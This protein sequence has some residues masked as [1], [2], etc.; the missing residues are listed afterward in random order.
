MS[1][2]LLVNSGKAFSI[3]KGQLNLTFHNVAKEYLLSNG[4]TVLETHVDSGY[5]IKAEV[6]KILDADVLIHQFPFWWMAY[7]W[8]TK[9]WIDEVFME[10]GG[11][12]YTSD[13]RHSD[14]P[15]KN[16]GKGGLMQGK[17]VMMSITTNAPIEA[18]DDPNEFF[19]GI[20]VDGVFLHIAKAHEFC[21]FEKLPTFVSFDVMKN[22]QVERDIEM[23]RDHLSKYIK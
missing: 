12:I 18:F 6:Q 19:G 14:N 21:G 17:K 8:I 5:D 16:Y 23:Y 22:P 9:K 11:K 3:S 15:T 2:I 13:G 10:G 1:K 7:P 20:G 4:H